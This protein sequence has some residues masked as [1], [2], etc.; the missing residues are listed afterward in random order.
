MI[1][2][3]KTSSRNPLAACLL[4]VAATGLGHIYCGRLVKG[5]ILF[6]ASFAFA[7][8]IVAAANSASSNLMLAMVIGSLGLMF[9]VF[10]YAVVDSTLLA[11][12]LEFYQLREY[13]RWYLYVL[14]IAVAAGYPTNLAHSI[15]THVLQAFKIPSSSMSPGI[16]PGDHILLNKAI[17][18]TQAPRRGDV[19]IFTYPD[20]RRLNYV[21][22]IV[23]MPGDTVE[24]LDNVLLVNDQPLDRSLDTAPA[25]DSKATDGQIILVEENAATAYP[26]IVNPAKPQSMPKITVPHGHCFLLGDNRS[27]SIDSRNFGP[28]QLADIQGR[29]DY[30]YWPAGSWSRL[31][32]YPYK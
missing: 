25:L 12:K 9:A 7:P 17:Y 15:R 21:K 30:I 28:V 3:S 18:K 19:V 31:G 8:V 6:F 20:D 2:D 32:L 13:N 16:L 11:R 5:L 24:I 29:L 22:R 27:H 14:L 23:A 4:S 26:I 1:P 10:M